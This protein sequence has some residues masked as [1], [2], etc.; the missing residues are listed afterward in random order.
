MSQTLPL[1]PLG[2]TLLPG[3]VLPLHVFEQRYR[4]L[5][6]ALVPGGGDRVPRGAGP[7]GR[8][9]CFGVVAIRRGHEVG[10]EQVHALHRV[11]CVAE[12]LHCAGTATA[13][14][15]WWPSAASASTC[16]G[17]TRAPARR[18]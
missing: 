18:T 4:D 3:Q 15:T 9:P 14:A 13:A 5:V 10:S 17:S 7:G 12:V 8:G 1:F 16:S 11:G 2:T 6:D